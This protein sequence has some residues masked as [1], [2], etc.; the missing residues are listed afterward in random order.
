VRFAFDA[1]DNVVAIAADEDPDRVRYTEEEWGRCF[2]T[3]SALQEARARAV[4]AAV[5]YA[6][7]NPLYVEALHSLL[8]SPLQLGHEPSTEAATTAR[9]GS[10]NPRG[11]RNEGELVDL[12]G[13]DL[14]PSP[15]DDSDRIRM[16]GECQERGLEHVM[17]RGAMLARHRKYVVSTV[18]QRYEQLRRAGGG[19]GG[20]GSCPC[21]PAKILDARAEVLARFCSSLSAGNRDMAVL[22]ATADAMQARQVYDD[23]PG[24]AA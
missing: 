14:S 5:L 4:R 24:G 23:E 2:A 3:S 6:R 22:L 1:G 10:R 11:R 9:G 20:T 16:I 15:I 8:A 18:L 7:R 21:S 12:L 17:A 19:G 13:I